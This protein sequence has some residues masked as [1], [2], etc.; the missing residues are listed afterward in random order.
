MSVDEFVILLLFIYIIV[1]YYVSETK[2]PPEPMI[3]YLPPK[4]AVPIDTMTEPEL[5]GYQ[6][7]GYLH[8]GFGG[9][10]EETLYDDHDRTLTLQ[11]YSYDRMIPLFGRDNNGSWNYYI[12]ADKIYNIKVPLNNKGYD[13]GGINGCP[14]LL[15]GDQVFLP[16]VNTVFTV[17]L[18][19]RKEQGTLES[20]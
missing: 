12:K 2:Q 4:V 1:N 14:E 10:P 6:N 9:T 18:F 8:S 19:F 13:C 7:I 5:Y 3:S 17:R 20:T 15:D 11:E 16:H